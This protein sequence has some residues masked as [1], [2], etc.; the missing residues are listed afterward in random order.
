MH[1][2][3]STNLITSMIMHLKKKR[4]NFLIA[5]GVAA[6][7][8]GVERLTMDL[9]LAVSI[10]KENLSKFLESMSELGLVPRLPLQAEVL[11]DKNKRKIMVEEKNA[12]VFT[13]IDPK[14]PLR[15]IDFFMAPGLSFEELKDDVETINIDGEEVFILSKQKL[16]ELKLNVSPM[17]DK[18][19]FDIKELQR[20][21]LNEKGWW[22]VR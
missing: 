11:L 9:D 10:E 13:F 19:M 2:I 12:L 21:I 7:L 18:D 17:R 3:D 5:G 8:H 6:V 4:V 1:K 20:L 16:V 15:Q 14:T 22:G